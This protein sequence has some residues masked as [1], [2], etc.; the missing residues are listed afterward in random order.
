VNGANAVLV[1]ALWARIEVRD[2][3]GVGALLAEDFV[4]DWPHSR[5][6]IRGRENFV[7]L[8]RNYPE[9]WSIEVLRIV[10][11]GDIVVS[12]VRVPHRDLG[13]HYVASFFEVERGLL[14]RGREY[15]VQEGQQEP[16]PERA[17]WVESL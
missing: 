5:E 3:P 6:R 13:V 9:G 11:E 8:N 12:E 4:M 1:A 7:E 2:W 14:A 17:H 15:W 16:P 10:S